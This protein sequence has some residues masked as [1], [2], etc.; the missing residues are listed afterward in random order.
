MTR[1]TR[2]GQIVAVST[3]ILV[4]T[5][6][7]MTAQHWN[8]YTKAVTEVAEQGTVQAEEPADEEPQPQDPRCPEVYSDGSSAT[9][10]ECDA[11]LGIR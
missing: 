10:S 1:L 4:S 6:L 8:P 5:G 2:R 3:M 11:M 9:P 7:G